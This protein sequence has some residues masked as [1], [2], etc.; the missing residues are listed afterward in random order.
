MP[1]IHNHSSDF[2]EPAVCGQIQGCIPSAKNLTT[3]VSSWI[4]SFVSLKTIL[5]CL[6]VH[7]L[8]CLNKSR[9]AISSTTGMKWYY[10]LIQQTVPI[11]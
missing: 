11:V 4:I 8:V 2:Q 9:G 6:I 7:F 3:S 5:C 10:I 1:G